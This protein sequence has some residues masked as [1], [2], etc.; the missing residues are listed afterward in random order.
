MAK[1]TSRERSEKHSFW[2]LGRSKWSAC[3]RTFAPGVTS[4]RIFEVERSVAC[5][6]TFCPRT[7]LYLYS[8][9]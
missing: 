1:D 9:D 5:D 7:A 3:A 2:M 4:I 8:K 6:V